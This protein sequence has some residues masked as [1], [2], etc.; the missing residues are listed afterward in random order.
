MYRFAHTH[1]RR[2][3]S[4]KRKFS[5]PSFPFPFPSSTLLLWPLRPSVLHRE[6]FY[7]FYTS[8]SP[9]L[10]RSVCVPP[11]T[12]RKSHGLKGSGSIESEQKQSREE[13]K[14]FAQKM[15]GLQNGPLGLR[16]ISYMLF[17]SNLAISH[18]ISIKLE[19][20]TTTIS[21]NDLSKF[22]PNWSKGTQV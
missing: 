8:I 16:R 3:K 21:P 19:S 22:Q 12:K 1:T 13:G 14:E 10:S 18:Q 15:L 4:H 17:G 20:H 2:R 11:T 9:S 6:T 5:L 7:L